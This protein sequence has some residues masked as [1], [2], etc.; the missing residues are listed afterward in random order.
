MD[1]TMFQMGFGE[2]ILLHQEKS[3]LLVDC[4]SESPCKKDYFD[5]VVQELKQYDQR[6]LLISHFHQD[7]INGIETLYK[8]NNR[9]FDVVYLPDIFENGNVALELL[10]LQHL[11]ELKHKKGEDYQIWQLLYDLIKA[12]NNVQLIQKGVSFEGASCRFK[13]L[14]PIKDNKKIAAQWNNIRQTAHVAGFPIEEE[15]TFIA[16]KLRSAVQWL[17]RDVDTFSKYKMAKEETD[18]SLTRFRDLHTD[19]VKLLNAKDEESKRIRE[20]L[21]TIFKEFK[22]NEYSIVF[23]TEDDYQLQILMTGDITKDGMKEIKKNLTMPSVQLKD[24]YDVY[25][26]PHH[27]TESHYCNPEFV[28]DRLL[29]SN[30][31]TPKYKNRGEISEQYLSDN[32]A[33]HVYCTNAM[34]RR[35]SYID[36]N[37]KSA[38]VCVD[39]NAEGTHICCTIPQ[40][41]PINVPEIIWDPAGEDNFKKE[42]LRTRKAKITWEYSSGAPDVTPW[43]ANKVTASTNLRGNIQSRPQWREK[44]SNGLMRV[45]VEI[46]N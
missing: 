24:H 38:K 19:Y 5:N 40:R 37:K 27:G 45:R 20:N 8:D 16:N 44:D 14:W 3:C 22:E 46:E 33:Q 36:Q 23:H 21:K 1:I 6:S 26:A 18:V 4:G 2:S 31:E 25:K 35:C 9:F 29:I 32:R 43:N 11:M 30:G 42:L 39:C 12:K 28:Y 17:T 7:H 34:K 13:A 41:H 10:I 15:I